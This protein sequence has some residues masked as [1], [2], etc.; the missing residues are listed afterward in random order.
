MST[1]TEERNCH[2]C[3]DNNPTFASLARY[4]LRVIRAFCDIFVEA[5]VKI[6]H[7]QASKMISNS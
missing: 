6:L 3:A 1:H 2:V 5:E 7:A 4:R